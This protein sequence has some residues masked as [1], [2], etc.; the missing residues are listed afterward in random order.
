MEEAEEPIIEIIQDKLFWLSSKQ[1]PRNK[2]NSSYFC[3]DKVRF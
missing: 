3:I 2:E 1:P